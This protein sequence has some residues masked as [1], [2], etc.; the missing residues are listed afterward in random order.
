MSGG[1]QQWNATIY[2][3]DKAS[4]LHYF[5]PSR[6]TVALKKSHKGMWL[7]IGENF[8][9]LRLKEK[10]LRGVSML[11]WLR[12]SLDRGFE[13]WTAAFLAAFYVCQ[14]QCF[15]S[16]ADSHGQP[17]KGGRNLKWLTGCTVVA[18][19]KEAWPGWASRSFT[20]ISKCRQKLSSDKCVSL[21]RVSKEASGPK[22]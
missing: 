3:D 9:I 19:P 21:I 16:S 17:V 2:Q 8:V 7:Y 6:L 15:G 14:H 11:F 10:I 5:W 1:R 13:L 18:E 22:R 12:A 20:H 4:S